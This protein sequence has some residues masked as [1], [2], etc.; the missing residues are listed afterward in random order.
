MLLKMPFSI[1]QALKIA[2]E[3]HAGQTDKAGQP[4][5]RHLMRVMERVRSEEEKIVALLH[6]LLEDTP[7]TAEKLLSAGCPAHLVEAVRA[8]TKKEGEA[9]ADFIA[10]AAQTPLARHV[11]LA[12][13]EDNLDLRR[14]PQLE[15]KD[16]ERINKYLKAYHFLKTVR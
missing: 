12:D 5:L 13:L 2:Q 15:H 4:Y 7:F 9:Y 14:L 3:A 1:A 11:K 8:L 6:D 16:L 10:R